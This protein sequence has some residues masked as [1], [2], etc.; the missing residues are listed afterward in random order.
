MPLQCAHPPTRQ[1]R[2]GAGAAGSRGIAALSLRM[3]ARVYAFG[4]ATVLFV[5]PPMLESA[6]FGLSRIPG[7]AA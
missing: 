3:P 5:I 6:R 1:S 2:A 7:P 4:E